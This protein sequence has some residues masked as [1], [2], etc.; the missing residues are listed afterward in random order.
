M[1]TVPMVNE[2]PFKASAQAIEDV[3]REAKHRL[4]ALRQDIKAGNKEGAS[5][6]RRQNSSKNQAGIGK[7]ATQP[8]AV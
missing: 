4:Y 6:F 7:I 1:A 5:H 8:G 2:Q 3:Y